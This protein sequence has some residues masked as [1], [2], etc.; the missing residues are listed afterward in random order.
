MQKLKAI[1]FL[2]HIF[3][4]PAIFS[5]CKKK[6]YQIS[7]YLIRLFSFYFYLLFLLLLSPHLPSFL[8]TNM[9]LL[10]CLIAVFSVV[11]IIASPVPD[12]ESPLNGITDFS[13][14]SYRRPPPPPHQILGGNII[15]SQGDDDASSV[16]V[17]VLVPGDSQDLSTALGWDLATTTTSPQSDTLSQLMYDSNGNLLAQAHFEDQLSSPPKKSDTPTPFQKYWHAECGGTK[18]VCCSGIGIDASYNE[19][20]G[21]PLPC[22]DSMQL[23]FLFFLSFLLSFL[24]A[25]K[26]L[27]F[28]K[29]TSK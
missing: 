15:A 29:K 27:F 25:T 12:A 5:V 28:T 23:S 10:T 11:V 26:G 9:S 6:H 4:F 1:K 21:V 14:G 22:S 2:H 8:P 19:Q 13:F 3:G 20:P 24:Q 16:P 7:I 17:P 18:S